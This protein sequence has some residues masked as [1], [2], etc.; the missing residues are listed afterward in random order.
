M[1]YIATSLRE[2]PELAVFL[3]LALGFVVGR[4]WNGH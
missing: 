2:H 4:F 3:T 1:S